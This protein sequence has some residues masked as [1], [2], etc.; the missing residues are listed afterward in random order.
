[1]FGR[2]GLFNYSSIY[3]LIFQSAAMWSGSAMAHYQDLP[4]FSDVYTQTHKVFLFAQHYPR[5]SVQQMSKNAVAVDVAVKAPE[6]DLNYLIT[7]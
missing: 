1:M 5:E 6:R 4:V 7:N 2:F 3:F